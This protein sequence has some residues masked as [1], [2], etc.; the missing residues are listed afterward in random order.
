MKFRLADERETSASHYITSLSNSSVAR[1]LVLSGDCKDFIVVGNHL[2]GGRSY[3]NLLSAT[4][5]YFNTRPCCNIILENTLTLADGKFSTSTRDSIEN[6]ECPSV[7]VKK[8]KPRPKPTRHC[9]PGC[10]L[11]HKDPNH[12]CFEMNDDYGSY[13]TCDE[14]DPRDELLQPDV[15]DCYEQKGVLYGSGRMI[16]PR[17]ERN[18]TFPAKLELSEACGVLD[19]CRQHR[20][21]Y[22]S[23]KHCGDPIELL[24]PDGC[25]FIVLKC[26]KSHSPHKKGVSEVDGKFECY[27]RA[28]VTVCPHG[29]NGHC[30]HPRCKDGYHHNDECGMGCRKILADVVCEKKECLALEHTKNR[31]FL[32]APKCT[33]CDRRFCGHKRCVGGFHHHHVCKIETC[34]HLHNTSQHSSRPL[35]LP[36][37]NIGK[38]SKLGFSNRASR[39]PAEPVDHAVER[40]PCPA[41]C[42]GCRQGKERP[43]HV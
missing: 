31:E 13:S 22:C 24:I 17:K 27:T 20:F 41:S 34:P 29:T 43:K 33:P 32:R 25:N 4:R 15:C 16:P 42:K 9:V 39:A 35:P 14:P 2:V 23:C 11:K 37:S 40:K 18:F 21:E 8:P 3:G 19:A 38:I 30:D 6:H 10:T 26:D 1:G 36:G 12:Y 28:C 7:P 5:G